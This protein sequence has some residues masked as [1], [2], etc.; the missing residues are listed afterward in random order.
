MQAHGDGPTGGSARAP[1]VPDKAGLE[2]LEAKWSAR[3]EAERTYAFDRSRPRSEVYAIDTPPPTVSG[4][5]HI[6]HVFSYTQ[7][8]TIARFW[9]MRGKDV[10]YPM[11]WDDNGLPTERRVQNYY[12]VRCDPSLPYDP[13]FVAP[14]T[15]PDPPVSVS[16]RNFVELCHRQTAA[17]EQVFERLW[18]TVGLSV[19][20]EQHYTTISDRAQRASQRGFLHL[21]QQGEVYA[22]TAPT[23]WDVDFQTAVSNAELEERERP[24]AYHRVRFMRA[25]GS[26][27]SVDIET[28]R[29][30][31]LAACVALV[32]HPDD[33]RYQPLFGTDVVTPLFRA[34]VPVVAHELADPEKGSGIAMICTFGDT[35]DVVW[36]RELSL[37][38]RVIVGR[39]GRLLPVE[40][41]SA[42]WE[43]EDPAAAGER[44]AQLEGRTIN[45]AQRRVVELLG[46]AGALVG[47]PTPITH[48]VKFYEKGERPLE[49]V[50]SRQWF[51]RTLEHRPVCSPA[52]T[53]CA[54]T[55]RTWPSATDPGSRASTR[56]G[57]SAASASSGSP[58]RCGTRWVVTA[59]PTS[60][61]PSSPL[62]TG[63]R[64]ILRSTRRP[65]STRPGAGSRAA[66]DGH[67]APRGPAGGP[68]PDVERFLVNLSGDGDRKSRC[69]FDQG[70]PADRGGVRDWLEGGEVNSVFQGRL[71]RGIDD[72][73]VA[74]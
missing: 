1:Q 61:H 62:R 12:G 72:R 17:D 6:G 9:R 33:F 16:R 46:E 53:S 52:G 15:P 5:L 51:V 48:T 24:G 54:G 32:A 67:P 40:W 50:T 60:T 74:P 2:G 39:D 71:A 41:G 10:F 73:G 20:W 8:D 26:D 57:T 11:G 59:T 31:L 44:Y 56:T 65:A 37:P 36:W 13:G 4:A 30:E 63:C 23:L 64:W 18:R 58:S 22:R 68:V 25:D 69:S 38:T 14:E 70:K 47:G 55:P 43:S 42:G 49:I 66:S 45:Q 3:W 29:P 28:T 34:R 21:V 19:D 35:T 27:G 7:T